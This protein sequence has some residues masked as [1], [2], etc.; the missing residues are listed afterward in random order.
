MAS[1]A[2]SPEARDIAYH[3]HPYTNLRKLAEDGPLVIARGEGIHVYDT[4]DKPYIEGLAGL[5]CAGLGFSEQRLVDAAVRQMEKL[6]FYHAFTNKVSDVTTE[7]AERLVELAPVPMS[8]AILES[9]GSQANDTIIKIVWYYNNA[10]GRPEKKKFISRKRG[11]H[12]VT[13]AAA[14]LTG[15]PY[16]QTDFDV[17]FPFVRHVTP[18]HAFREMAPGEDEAA[19]VDRLAQE[20]DDLIEAEGPETVAAFI[21]EPIQGAGGVILPPAGYFPK[22]QAVLDKHDVLMVAD[23]V[24]CG[25]GRTGNWWGSQ[26]FDIRP[27]IMSMAKQLTAAYMPLSAVMIDDK[28]FQVLA[29]NSAKRGNFGHGYTYSGHPVPAAVGLETLRIYED[30]GIVD[31]V[32]AVGPHLQAGLRALADHPLVGDARGIGLIGALEL[33]ADKQTNAAFP[34]ERM[35]GPTAVAHCQRH[36]LILRNLPGDIVAVCPPMIITTG[37]IDQLLERLRAALDD[38]LA[39]IQAAG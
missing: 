2:N 25:F 6:P 24:I 27:N 11:Y 36:G 7:L 33:V 10:L 14:S 17:P 16:A 38:T 39:D 4:N 29:D 1:A 26:T 34:V 21:A 35:V 13:L 9:S 12:G 22:I 23:E 28:V 5:W 37:E 18:P 20:V 19:F 32:R 31:R 30:D 8:K 15:L 3:L